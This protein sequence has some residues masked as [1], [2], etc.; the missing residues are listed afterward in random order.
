MTTSWWRHNRH[1]C[2]AVATNRLLPT[3]EDRSARL[4]INA[5][6]PGRVS[7]SHEWLPSRRRTT[8]RRRV[9]EATT[10]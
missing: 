5:E 2:Q 6:Q 3:V 8:R 10:S 9:G 1:A 7:G 4:T